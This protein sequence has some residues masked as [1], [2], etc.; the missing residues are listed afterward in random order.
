MWTGRGDSKRFGCVYRDD[1]CDVDRRCE[2]EPNRDRSCAL[3]PQGARCVPVP[4]P[5][6]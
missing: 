6:P 2:P 4:D 5:P 3:T 1:P